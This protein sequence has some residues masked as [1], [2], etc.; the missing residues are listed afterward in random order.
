[1][2][3]PDDLLLR[4]TA[5]LRDTAP[6][7]A[8]TVD[9]T[10]RRLLAAVERRPRRRWRWRLPI[11]GATLAGASLAWAAATDRL[12]PRADR[13]EAPLAAPVDGVRVEVSRRSRALDEARA[14]DGLV[15]AAPSTPANDT[16]A[17]PVDGPAVEPSA[18]G[19]AAPVARPARRRSTPAPAAS[20][21]A[22]RIDDAARVDLEAYRRAHALH[23]RG[24]DPAATLAA[25]DAY[26]D[27]HPTG[28]FAAEARYNR[29][30][31]LVRLD[32]RAE[33]AAALAPFADGQV[34][35]GYRQREA[36]ALR[37]ALE[38]P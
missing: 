6:A 11:I 30:L 34:D 5:A 3:E 2:A 13:A 37:D 27:A 10:R 24:G 29:A 20:T 25:W 14:T 18:P 17:R 15:V 4:A 28:R 21:P 31:T 32:R 19:P 8:A 35:G 38:A 36:R 7:D 22:D 12:A 23:F 1:M 26:L 33:A 9:A 16:P